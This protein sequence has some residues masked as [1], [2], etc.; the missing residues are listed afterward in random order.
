MTMLR[1]C[2]IGALAFA[3][4]ACTAPSDRAP[5]EDSYL[6]SAR[7]RRRSLEASLVTRENDYARI[8]LTHY[9]SGDAADWEHLSEW[10]PR[11]EP[12]TLADVGTDVTRRLGP[13]ASALS[14]DDASGEEA[15]FRYPVQLVRSARAALASRA[16]LD[17]AGFWIDERRGVGGLVRVEVADGST[18]LA[19]T[20]AT[21]HA[22]EAGSG[23]RVGRANERLDLG[24]GPGRVDV[25]TREGSEPAR[26]PDLR[27]V[28]FLTHL[29]QDA[30][31]A[32]PDV[33]ALA[34]RLETLVITSHSET[35]RPPRGL[36]LALSK[37][38]WSLADTLPAVAPPSGDA[39]RGAGTF[40]ATCSRCHAPPAFTGPP[41]PLATVGTDPVLGRS[42]DRSTG[43]YRVPSLR[44][45][46]DRG[47]LLHDG[48]VGSLE[49][50]F[51]PR[52]RDST[53]EGG[54]IPGHVWGLDLDEAA[55]ADLVAFLRSL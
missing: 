54:S 11:T 17:Q 34:I 5:D 23:L 44:G 39:A 15:F 53:F 9:A 28:R 29:H 14:I 22:S 20:C 31:L 47:L 43:M 49:V 33:T 2:V 55:R 16:A 24:W 48:R 51:D 25:T 19:Y 45:V 8:R 26:V 32:Q 40:A 41:V 21:C 4:I 10:N 13:A 36:I 50:L 37:Y 18:S 42:R 6:G 52:R 1:A 35:V 27:P 46:S 30:T 12:V 38:V 3:S 7:Y